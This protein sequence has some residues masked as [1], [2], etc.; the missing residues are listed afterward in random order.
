MLH[1]DDKVLNKRKNDVL[2]KQAGKQKVHN[3]NKLPPL[4]YNH[5]F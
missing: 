5:K 2:F 1:F 3:V 4:L